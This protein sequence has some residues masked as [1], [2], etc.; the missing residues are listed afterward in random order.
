M[1]A[2]C[3]PVTVLLVQRIDWLCLV[4]KAESASW[5]VDMVVQIVVGVDLWL[6]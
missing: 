5:V 3:W 6:Q 1:H 4:V 2:G